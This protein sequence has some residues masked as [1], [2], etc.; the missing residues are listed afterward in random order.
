[1]RAHAIGNGASA[2][3]LNSC[4][5]PS[6]ERC[7]DWDAPELAPQ[8]PAFASIASELEQ[9]TH[10]LPDWVCRRAWRPIVFRSRPDKSTEAHQEDR[11][12]S[13]GDGGMAW[14]VDVGS[15]ASDG[16]SVVRE[17]GVGA[18]VGTWVLVCLGACTGGSR[19]NPTLPRGV[20]WSARVYLSTAIVLPV[21][22]AGGRQ[23]RAVSQSS[24]Q[25]VS[26]SLSWPGLGVGSAVPC[27]FTRAHTLSPSSQ[28]AG[29]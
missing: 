20:S 28:M 16:G 2:P 14:M 8:M 12:V 3:S 13:A 22:L 21:S 6:A 9:E 29:L 15:A 10:N 24:S 19:Q 17:R 7:R 27:Q 4:R 1:M 18:W 11:A 25:A 5:P 26:W 23:G